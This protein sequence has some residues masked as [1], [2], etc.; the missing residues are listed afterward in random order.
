MPMV[1]VSLAPVVAFLAIVSTMTAVAAAGQTSDPS[2]ERALIDRYCV[3][4]H[5]DN[6][7]TAGLALDT[8]DVTNVGDSAEV[9]EKVVTK[10]RA[11]MMPPAGRPQPDD[12]A[13]ASLYSYLETELDRAAASNPDPGRSDAPRQPVG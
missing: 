8:I 2:P 12:A 3:T 4:C 11:G 9:W 1:R 10:L 6:M 13:K 5:N 7:R